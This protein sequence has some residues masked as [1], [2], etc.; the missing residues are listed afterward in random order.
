MAELFGEDVVLWIYRV[1]V[2]S[3]V[4]L[5]VF[6]ILGNYYSKQDVRASEALAL[7]S[8]IIDC[9]SSNGL[10]DAEKISKEQLLKCTNAD[11]AEI[12]ANV[13]LTSQSVKKSASFGQDV[14][15]YCTAQEKGIEMKDNVQCLRQKFY[16]LTGDE[17]A[18]LNLVIGIKKFEKNI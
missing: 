16:I 13:T 18:N 1:G 5:G 9:I 3:I 12:Y 7:S 10:V 11:E 8:R 4:I 2:I 15:F 17:Q 6:I 14:A